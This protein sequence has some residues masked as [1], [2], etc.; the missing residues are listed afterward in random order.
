MKMRGRKAVAV[1]VCLLLVSAIA[2]AAGYGQK[3][4]KSAVVMT[5]KDKSYSAVVTM[6]RGQLAE[7]ARQPGISLMKKPIYMTSTRIAV[8]VPSTL[9]GGFIIAEPRALA[10][11]LNAMGL[12]TE[13]TAARVLGA[14]AAG[15]AI[16]KGAAV[17]ATKVAAGVKTGT[18]VVGVLIGA[19]VVGGVIAAAS[20][21]GETTT[22][23]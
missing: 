14:T 19:G 8:P 4:T 9:G 13:A 3:G 18:V 12:T 15:G 23:H 2:P 20:G 7:L 10:D 1:M 21:G 5:M 22:N 16:T 11:G 6:N 17:S